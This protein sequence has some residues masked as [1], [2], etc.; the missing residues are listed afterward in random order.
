[1]LII[2]EEDVHLYTCM[3]ACMYVCVHKCF[4]LVRSERMQLTCRGI[5][6]ETAALCDSLLS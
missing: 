4:E 1:M 5:S 3:R 2:P 6:G